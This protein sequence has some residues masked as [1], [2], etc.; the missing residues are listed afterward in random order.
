MP[1]KFKYLI[2]LVILLF[3]CCKSSKEARNGR[4]KLKYYNAIYLGD[5]ETKKKYDK[6]YHKA[7]KKKH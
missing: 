7:T 2:F 6:K 5:K 1:K 4:I 3:T